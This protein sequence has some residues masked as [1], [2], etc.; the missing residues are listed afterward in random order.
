MTK[1]VPRYVFAQLAEAILQAGA[2]RATKYLSEKLTVKATLHGKRMNRAEVSN[3][4]MVVSVGRP[5]YAERQ[6]IRQCKRAGE[7]FPIK[8]L[9]LKWAQPQPPKAKARR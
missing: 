3:R 4:T 6:F 9:Q 5:N 8:R 2:K 7:P 1:T